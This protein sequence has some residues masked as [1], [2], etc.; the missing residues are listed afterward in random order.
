[1]GAVSGPAPVGRFLQPLAVIVFTVGVGAIVLVAGDTLGYDFRAY[2]DAARRLLDGRPLYDPNVDVAGGFAL[3]LYPPPFALA[4]V[5]LAL[6]PGT[7][8]PAV[9]WTALLVAAL[10]VAIGVLPVRPWVRWTLLLVAGLT[11]PVLY[12]I[13]LGQV[14]PLLLLSFAVAWRFV[15]RPLPLGLSIAAGTLIKL[16]PALLLPWALIVGRGRAAAIAFAARNVLARRWPACA[17]SMR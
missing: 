3:Y 4:L 5:P 13:K 15:D 11:W 12:A 1:M 8:I 16:Q 6:L 2:L 9:T 17:Q 7:V 14:G 10:V